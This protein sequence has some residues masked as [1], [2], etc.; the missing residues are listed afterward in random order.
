MRM[1]QSLRLIQQLHLPAALSLLLLL[2]ALPADSAG[3]CEE[4]AAQAELTPA[5]DY[6]NGGDLTDC[7]PAPPATV[8]TP[9]P[10]ARCRLATNR[11]FDAS[12]EAFRPSIQARAPPQ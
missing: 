9:Q 6:G 7:D 3:A 4:Q 2:F 1:P 8:A 5:W 10:V 12:I 11:G